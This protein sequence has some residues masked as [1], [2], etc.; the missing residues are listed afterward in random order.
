MRPA[1]ELLKVVLALVT[2]LGMTVLMLAALDAVPRALQPEVPRLASVASVEEA[3]K[4]LGEKLAMPSYFPESLA[5]PPSQVRI[6]R[7]T[8]PT[9]SIALLGRDGGGPRVLLCQ[10]VGGEGAVSTDL[11]APPSRV[12]DS[13]KVEVAGAPGSLAR[14]ETSDGVLWHDLG[15]RHGGQQFVLRTR[16]TVTEALMMAASVRRPR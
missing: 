10:T 7:G 14:I 4:R 1:L 15:W 12:L 16:G 6:A 9:V 5:W 13:R 11:L 3:E 8:P 2:V